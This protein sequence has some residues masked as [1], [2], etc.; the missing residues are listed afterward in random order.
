MSLHRIPDRRLGRS[1]PTLGRAVRDSDRLIGRRKIVFPGGGGLRLEDKI[2]M[3]CR[4][5]ATN[6][7]A[8]SR[9]SLN[10]K[11]GFPYPKPSLSCCITEVPVTILAPVASTTKKYISDG[12]YYSRTLNPLYGDLSGEVNYNNQN[13]SRNKN[14]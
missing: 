14:T 10:M 7:G 13:N 4:A 8:S 1:A 11:V 9:L 6:L 3:G 2:M 5:V 12:L